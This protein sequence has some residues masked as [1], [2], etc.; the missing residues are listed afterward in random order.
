MDCGATCLRMIAAYYGRYYTLEFLRTCTGLD[1]EGVSFQ[2]LE[3]G[4]E[5]I[6][7]RSMSI[8]LPFQSDDEVTGLQ[9]APLPCI[10]PWEEDHFVVVTAIHR[11]YIRIADPRSGRKKYSIADFLTHWK[12]KEEE[13]KALLLEP[14]AEFYSTQNTSDES[15]GLRYLF[16]Y[17]HPYKRLGWQLIITLILT[18]VF[19]LAF[20]FLTQS[21]VDTGIANQDIDFIYLVLIGLIMLFL[22]RTIVGL[23]QSWML[24]HLGTR[25]NIALITDFLRKMM[26]LPLSFFDKKMTGDLLQRLGDHSRIDAFLTNSTLS[27]VFSVFTFAIFSVVLLIYSIKVFLIFVLGS[28]LYIGWIWLWLNKRATVDH[29]R[30]KELADNQ[31]LLIELIQGIK[32]I[33][34]QGS[35][36]KRQNKWLEVQIRLFNANIRALTI[37]QYQDTGAGF[38]HQLKDILITFITAKAVIDGQMTLGMMLSVQYITGQLSGPLM[39]FVGFIRSAQ[40]AQLSLERMQEI[41]EHKEELLPDNSHPMIMG[42]EDIV[43]NQLSFFYNSQQAPVLQNINLTIPSGKITA[44]VGASGS[45]KTTLIKLLLGFYEESEGHMQIGNYHLSTIAP[46]EWR[47]HCGAVLQDG[48]LFADTI[49]NNIAE[50]DDKIDPTKLYY[51]AKLAHL[52]EFIQELPLGFD[53]KV[54]SRGQHL[55]Q[56]QKQRILIARA[57]YKN[58]KYLFFDEAT[59]ALDAESETVIVNNLN[60]FFENRT[61]VIAAHRLSTVKNADQIVVLHKGQIVEIGTHQALVQ[62]EG[63]YYNLVKKQLEL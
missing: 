15:K 8:Y 46:K 39:Q 7:L 42:N 45:G 12:G 11:N 43:L 52:E 41:H 47:T 57:I 27:L 51:A 32:E 23:L 62:L 26:K 17:L 9:E 18:G 33:K 58:P 3:D 14:A 36:K 10:I 2:G 20:P 60:H 37:A 61:V 24:L 59:N 22:G 38:I 13:G 50:S 16:N 6:G 56:G 48:F 34:L 63:Y 21:I 53:T 55:S 49:A 44:L 28:L 30:F 54:G 1:R 19:Q 25:I 29:Q 4:A 31:E 40:D 35:G 5:M